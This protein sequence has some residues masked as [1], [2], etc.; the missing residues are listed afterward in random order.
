MKTY[1]SITGIYT[2]T[3]IIDNKMI[4]GYTSNFTKRKTDHFKALEE[5]KHKNTY[6]QNAYNL[7]GKDNFK[8]AVLEYCDKEFLA[9]QEHY[10]CTLLN[11][12]NRD[13]GYNLRPTNPDDRVS[14]SEETKLKMSIGNTGKT[15]TENRKKE[16]SDSKKDWKPSNKMINSTIEVCSKPVTQYDILGN[17]IK[18]WKSI[19]E[20]VNTLKYG[21][22]YISLCCNNKKE[23]YKNYIWKFKN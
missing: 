4:I 15:W 9:S 18:N 13:I 1:E 20:I 10:W 17:P 14:Q 8:F 19:T 5:N 16:F 3:N 11:T 2:I 12:H 7:H 23:S 21:K 22:K 6:L